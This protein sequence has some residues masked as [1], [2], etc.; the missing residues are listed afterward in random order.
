MSPK[1]DVVIENLETCSPQD[2]LR[3]LIEC[4]GGAWYSDVDNDDGLSGVRGSGDADDVLRE[5][6]SVRCTLCGCAG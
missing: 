5:V 4:M 1:L 6:E 3:G 2:Y